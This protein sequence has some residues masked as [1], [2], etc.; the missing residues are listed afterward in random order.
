[1]S[2]CRVV[3]VNKRKT[4]DLEN[5]RNT[6]AFE[7]KRRSISLSIVCIPTPSACTGIGSCVVGSTFTIG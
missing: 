7:N 3:V 4:I 2:E 5:K 1:M 6:I